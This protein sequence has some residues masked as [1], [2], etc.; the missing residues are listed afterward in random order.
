MKRNDTRGARR[1][2][3]VVALGLLA[4][5]GRAG[6]PAE[7]VCQGQYPQHLQGV[8]A[9]AGAIYWSFTTVLVKTDLEGRIL[10]RAE[11]PS[12]HGDLCVAGGRVIVAWSNLFNRPGADSKVYLY[13]ADDLTLLEIKPVPEVTFGAGGVDHREGRFYIVG[14]LPPDGEENLVYEYDAEFRHVKTHR[15]PSGYT[16]LGIQTACFHDGRWWFGCYVKNGSPGLL[17]CDEDLNLL[18]AH[19]V[20]PSIGLVGWGPGRFMMAT[21]VGEPYGAKLVPMRADEQQGLARAELGTQ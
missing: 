18:G 8:A 10:A 13:D 9:A 21:H 2:V 7:I 6:G 12:H 11:V 16:C 19:A 5:T 4:G 1:F 20:S 14:G 15:I 17:V 3:W